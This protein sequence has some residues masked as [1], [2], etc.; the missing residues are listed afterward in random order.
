MV[1]FAASNLSH[2]RWPMSYYRLPSNHDSELHFQPHHSSESHGSGRKH[3]MRLMIIMQRQ[4]HLL[5]L[6]LQAD[7]RA[8]SRAC[9]TAGNNNAIKMAIIAI[10]T[11]NSM[12]VNPRWRG[13]CWVVNIS[14]DSFKREIAVIRSR[15]ADRI[16]EQ[17]YKVNKYSNALISRWNSTNYLIYT[18]NILNSRINS[19]YLGL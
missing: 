3:A 12:S 8:A 18:N 5:K 9:C 19:V 4:A 1:I 6:F 13:F 17:R 2:V 14:R 10:T 16:K 11:S 15:T 7:R